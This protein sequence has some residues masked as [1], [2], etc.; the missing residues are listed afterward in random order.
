MQHRC[1]LFRSFL[2]IAAFPD[3]APHLFQSCSGGRNLPRSLLGSTAVGES[4]SSVFAV[5]TTLPPNSSRH[6]RMFSPNKEAEL[7]FRQQL[8]SISVSQNNASF[9]CLCQLY[10]DIIHVLTSINMCFFLFFFSQM[11]SD[12]FLSRQ[13]KPRNRQLRKPLVVQV[14]AGS[15]SIHQFCAWLGG[16][17][18]FLSV[19]LFGH[20]FL[21][22]SEHCCPELQ[23]TLLNMSAP[24]PSFPTPLPQVLLRWQD[25]TIEYVVS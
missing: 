17:R 23:E 15:L 6:N 5:P 18:V 20:F 12:L 3:V 22:H 10:K 1:F 11:Q 21:I 25:R 7:A 19:F 2:Q 13:R 9:F 4:E 24:S 16:R 14:R 8:D